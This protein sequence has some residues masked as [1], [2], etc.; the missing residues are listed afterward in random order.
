M[1]QKTH[2]LARKPTSDV[3]K[4]K[5]LGVFVNHWAAAA[6]STAMTIVL[7]HLGFLQLF[8]KLSWLVLFSLPAVV[9][10]TGVNFQP[11]MPAVVLITEADFVTRYGEKTPLDRCVLAAD[12][13]KVLAKSPQRLA[14]DFD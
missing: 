9:P 6:F 7:E 11:G 8:T 5:V 10:E 1:T 13:Q 12:I 4:Q 3:R 14:I 2:T